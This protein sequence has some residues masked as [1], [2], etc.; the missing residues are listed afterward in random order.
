MDNMTVINYDHVYYHK[1]DVYCRVNVKY[2]T[3][4]SFLHV[5]MSHKDILNHKKLL[6]FLLLAMKLILGI[7]SK[8]TFA[9]QSIATFKLKEGMNLGCKS[10]MNQRFV[11][12]MIYKL[13]TYVLPNVGDLSESLKKNFN[14]HGDYES[15]LKDITL[16]QELNHGFEYFDKHIGMNYGYFQCTKN[17]PVDLNKLIISSLELPFLKGSLVH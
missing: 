13:K 5:H 8:G 14:N 17:T 16:Y 10:F 7:R 1:K 12:D 15:G 9:K 4:L 2:V 3:V 6:G 11:L